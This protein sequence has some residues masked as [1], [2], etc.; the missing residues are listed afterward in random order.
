[1]MNSGI[2]D[3]SDAKK[4]RSLLKILKKKD[5]DAYFLF[6]LHAFFFPPVAL[7]LCIESR[8]IPDHNKTE[9]Q[10]ACFYF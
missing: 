7:L 6:F 5:Q 2:P 1:M 8:E 9:L 4:K 10:L 3:R